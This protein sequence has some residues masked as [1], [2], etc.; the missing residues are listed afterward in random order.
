MKV[1][2][3]MTLLLTVS[4]S[5]TKQTESPAQ[6]KALA[7]MQTSGEFKA[8]AYQA[9]NLAELRVNERLKQGKG[10]KPFAIIVDADETI[11][12][13]GPYHNKNALS[14]KAYREEPWL[15]WEKE[16]KSKLT[17]EIRLLIKK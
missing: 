9:F 8:L 2:L 5:T 16:E 10:K 7:W 1:A 14:G 12:D 4:C 17:L 6:F 15:E 11:I 3:F 13:N